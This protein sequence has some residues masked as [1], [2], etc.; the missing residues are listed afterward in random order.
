ME[1]FRTVTDFEPA[2][3]ISKDLQDKIHRFCQG[4]KDVDIIKLSTDQV[5]LAYYPQLYSESFLEKQLEQLGVN[6]MNI[7]NNKGFFK[8]ILDKMA[9][10]NNEAFGGTE[11]E[12]CKLHKS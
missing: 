1:S 12:C 7:P 4:L 11:L 10:E 5:K 9:K 8:R 3:A 2:I 6:I